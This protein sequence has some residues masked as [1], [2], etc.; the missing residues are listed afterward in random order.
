MAQTI[1][2]P[3]LFDR[4]SSSASRE[5]FAGIP[6]GMELFLDYSIFYDD[7]TDIAIDATNSWTKIVDTSGTVLIKADALFGIAEFSNIG[8]LDNAGCSIQTNETFSFVSGKKTLFE[9]RVS[10]LDADDVDFFVGLV[11]NHATDPEAVYAAIGAGF[12]IAEGDA[13]ILAKAGLTAGASSE[14]TGVNAADDIFI[15]LGMLYDG[16]DLHFYVNREKK[17]TISAANITPNLLAPSMGFIAGAAA[18]DTI[19]CD[20]ILVMQER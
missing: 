6:V 3:L 12:R 4:Q 8:G 19:A 15:V 11:E 10:V 14:D 18:A 7:F 17:A 5:M 13:S 16:T 20:Y 1:P 9:A 2:G